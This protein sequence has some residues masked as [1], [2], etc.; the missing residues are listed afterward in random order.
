MVRLVLLALADFA[1]AV[2][3]N[4]VLLGYVGSGSDQIGKLRPVAPGLGV[5]ATTTVTVPATVPTSP[6]PPRR[7]GEDD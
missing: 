7:H 2:S 3:V 1:A 6:A 5:P 4:L